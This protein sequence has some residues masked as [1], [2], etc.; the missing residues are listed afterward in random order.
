[1]TAKQDM[2]DHIG[3]IPAAAALKFSDR[4]ALIFED[5]KFSFNE[6][7]SL[8]EKAAGGLSELGILPGDTVTLYAANSWEWIISYYA[9]ARIGAV[10][11]PVNTMLT[12]EELEYVAKDC[13]AKAIITMTHSGYNAIEISSHRPPCKIYAFTNN[14][15]ILNT[16]SLIWGVTGFYYDNETGTDET[17]A[18]TKRILREE[19][20]LQSKDL[21]LNVASMP[22]K[23]K[24]MTNMMRLSYLK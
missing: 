8:V 23:E 7:N 16:L 6:I 19:G 18:D 9:I 1:M 12:P 17:V 13:G 11:N 5:E 22:I 3:Q 24:G 2:F 10:I 15:A 4:T 21:V 20:F 14:H